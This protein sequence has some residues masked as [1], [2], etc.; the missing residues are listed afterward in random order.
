MK[1]TKDL[2]NFM[3]NFKASE[4][5]CKCGCETEYS[6]M[7]ALLVV[8]LQN[9]RLK[10]GQPIT[11]TSGHRCKKYNDSLA[12]S[13]KNSRHMTGKA[14]DFYIPGICDTEK[15]R[16]EVA[17]WLKKQVGYRNCYYSYD[18]KYKWMGSC[19]HVDVK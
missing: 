8:M 3:P 19:I 10:W 11:I 6:G 5:K 16:K 17:N 1:M 7:D 9:A 2:W 12:N 18:G 4:F 13:D 14:A 15:G